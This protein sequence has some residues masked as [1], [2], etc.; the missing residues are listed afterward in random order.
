MAK[1][2]S[3]KKKKSIT[4]KN[5]DKINR[6]IMKI[7]EV[8]GTD[9]IPYDLATQKI[10]LAGLKTYD[11]NGVTLVRNTEMNRVNHWAISKITRE[12]KTITQLKKKYGVPETVDPD[13][14]MDAEDIEEDTGEPSE[15][16]QQWYSRISSDFFDLI[17]E[18]YA[19]FDG[20]DFYGIPYSTYDVWNNEEYRLSKYEEI[21]EHLMADT[22]KAREFYEKNG[23]GLAEETGEVTTTVNENNA[24]DMN[25]NE[26]IT[27]HTDTD[28]DIDMD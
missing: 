24:A 11:K 20:C 26:I 8:F 9:S 2:R 5:I 23:Y 25:V 12:R 13:E 3:T 4:Q 1:K 27:D 22:D 7:A 19:C 21:F 10:F 15:T 28:I 14:W 6:N 16:F 18:V 17:D